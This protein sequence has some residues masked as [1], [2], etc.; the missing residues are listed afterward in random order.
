L[1]KQETFRYGAIVF[2]ALLMI[3]GFLLINRYRLI[4]RAR[5]QAAMEK[6]RN[7]IARD[8]HDDRKDLYLIFKE[9]VARARDEGIVR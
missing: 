8:L 5:Q 6:L 4:Q 7:N 2:I 3:V 1:Q 9:A